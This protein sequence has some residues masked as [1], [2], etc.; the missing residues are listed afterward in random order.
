MPETTAAALA[1]PSGLSLAGPRRL[2]ELIGNTPLVD[3]SDM[4]GRPE[5]R[6]LAK[7]ELANPGGSVKDRAALAIIVDAERRGLFAGGRRL[8]DS[9]SGNTG[10]A[11]AMIGAVRRIPVTLCMPANASPERR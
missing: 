5:V 3:L 7:A 11:Y 1:P 9:T 2:L 8:L 10:I 4:T 6:L